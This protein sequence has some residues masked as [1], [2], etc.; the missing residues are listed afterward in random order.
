MAA[1]PGGVGCCA[2]LGGGAAALP[3][4]SCQGARR[5]EI[6]PHHQELAEK[7]LFHYTE[8]AISGGEGP[9]GSVREAPCEPKPSSWHISLVPAH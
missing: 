9:V 6:Y 5:E 8:K 7:S 3:Q 2:K 1:S 4:P